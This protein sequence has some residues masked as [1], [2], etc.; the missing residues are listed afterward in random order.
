[1]IWR[2]LRS[3]WKIFALL[4]SI[5]GILTY[6]HFGAVEFSSM[7]CHEARV[8]IQNQIVG[9]TLDNYYRYRVLV[10]VGTN[11]FIQ[12]A[13]KM[14]P[15][16]KSFLAIYL[17]YDFFVIFLLLATLWIY[18]RE[19]FSSDQALVGVLF[20]AVS[21]ILTFR[22]YCYQP[23]SL[24]E[25]VFFTLALLSIYKN[26]KGWFA[27]WVVLAILN[28]ETGFFLP[29]LFLFA[30]W[31]RK[32]MGNILLGFAVYMMLGVLVY[33]LLHWVQGNATHPEHVL[34]SLG[35]YRSFYETLLSNLDPIHLRTALVQG[36][37]FMGVFWIFVWI[38][39]KNVP[40]PFLKRTAWIL[41]PYFAANL[42]Y[43]NWWEVR[44]LMSLYPILIPLALSALYRSNRI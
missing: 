21:M 39:L 5:A 10:P 43:N 20:A 33:T 9:G 30:N 40:S 8:Q 7:A 32:K 27:L 28:R 41:I 26:K 1:M 37:L 16:D 36:G 4:A 15:F 3:E 25:P 13:S 12:L 6:L 22:D 44:P 42:L 35:F 14:I 31:N 29:L 38:G 17:L 24:L 34:G 19:W 2:E 18:F 23:W 11:F